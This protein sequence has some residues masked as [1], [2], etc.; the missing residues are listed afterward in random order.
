MTDVSTE[1]MVF[2]STMNLIPY[3]L[4]DIEDC[5]LAI[6]TQS[7]FPSLVPEEEIRHLIPIHAKASLLA[8]S[9]SASLTASSYYI[10]IQIPEFYP[11]FQVSK[12]S[13]IP[14]YSRKEKNSVIYSVYNMA[15]PFVAVNS[16]LD[17]F[18][19]HSEA[20]TKRNS[21]TVCP[22]Y[23]IKIQTLPATCPQQIVMALDTPDICALTGTISDRQFQ[24]YI[25]MNNFKQVRIFSPKQDSL[26]YICGSKVSQNTTEITVGYTDVKFQP[27]CYLAT[28][29]LKIYSPIL[30]SDDTQ[31]E[32]TTTLPDLS[33]VMD[34]L[35]EYMQ[36][37]HQINMTSLFAD[38]SKL[39]ESISIE[40]IDVQSV[41]DTLKKVNI[42]R[43]LDNF[44]PTQLHLE[45]L[46]HLSTWT[47]VLFWLIAALAVVA[48]CCCCYC[49]CPACCGQCITCLCTS[50]C[51][52][53]PVPK[54]PKRLANPMRAFST[55]TYDTPIHYQTDT[56]QI[57]IPLRASAPIEQT[58]VTHTENAS[59][60]NIVLMNF[61]SVLSQKVYP[62]LPE[63]E[64][65]IP[66]VEPNRKVF[67]CG[68]IYYCL[69][70]CKCYN[71]DGSPS[72]KAPPTYHQIQQL[73]DPKTDPPPI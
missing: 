53:I 29:Q 58:Q 65:W 15:E 4:Q 63:T 56:S 47:G 50:L 22:P 21:I 36:V 24:S 55:N 1:F 14:W 46:S 59:D 51:R 38:F 42:M 48:T 18:S 16:Q 8:I 3:M 23:L 31:V 66:I 35:E 34:E 20:C 40:T 43:D 73:L 52:C 19:F 71:K 10:D 62:A 45:K 5:V 32:A 11:A 13:A 6:A 30:P 17:V 61:E 27:D 7:F 54:V 25:Y 69:S 72:N 2:H 70:K 28:T 33:G 44:N 67:K 64:K 39:Q 12:V 68:N 37:N 49:L 57:L 41:Q 26:S 9:I 60:A